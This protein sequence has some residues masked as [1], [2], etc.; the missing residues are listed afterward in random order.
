MEHSQNFTDTIWILFWDIENEKWVVGPLGQTNAILLR[1]L[2]AKKARIHL[3][4]L[5]C[6][7]IS[8]LLVT[9]G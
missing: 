1:F 5:L 8:S 4:E 9:F 3:T 7:D 2:R 6:L